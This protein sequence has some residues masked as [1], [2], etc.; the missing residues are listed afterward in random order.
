LKALDLVGHAGHRIHVARGREVRTM[1]RWLGDLRGLRLLDVGGGDG[2]WAAQAQRRGAL[3]F[4]VDL[5]PGRTERGRRFTRKPFLLR[6]D[7]LRLPFADGSF[8]AVMSVS[9]LEHFDSGADAIAEMS[10]VLRP[11]GSLVLSADSLAGSQRWPHLA[12]AHERR[13]RVIHPFDHEELRREL[14]AHGLEMTHYT[15][16]FKAAWTNRLY[17]ELSRKRWAWNAAAPL[18]PLIAACDRA[19]KSDRGSIVVV[20]ARRYS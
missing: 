16:L 4:S 19:S 18:S 13:Y 5:D 2:F 1:M 20:R 14:D 15:Y 8:D 9:S 7:A 6:G 3:A 11:G 17:L 10:R 12:A